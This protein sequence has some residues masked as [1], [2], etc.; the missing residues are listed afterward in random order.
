M[1]QF[2]PPLMAVSEAPGSSPRSTKDTPG[3]EVVARRHVDWREHR[4]RW[5]WLLDSYEGGERYRNAVYGRDR[6]GL[7]VRNLQ[8]HKREYPDLA[9][10]PNAQIGGS[11]GLTSSL[12]AEIAYGS[13]PGLLGADPNATSADDDYELRRSRTPPPEWVGECAEIHLGEVYDQEVKRDGPPELADEE[14]GWWADVD[15]KGTTIDDWMSLVISPMLLV[16]GQLDVLL[17]APPLPAG[18]QVKTLADVKRLGLDRCAASYILPENMLW[19]SLDRAG[20]YTE[21]VVQEFVDPSQW[22]ELAPGSDPKAS[23][24]WARDHVLFR[25]WTATYS[26]LYRYDGSRAENVREHPYGRVPIIRLF[27]RRKHRSAMVGKSRYEAVAELQREYYNRASELILSD[28][29][30]AHP[31]LSGPEQYCKPDG[32]L[33]IGPNF[34]LPKPKN[35]ADGTEAGKWEYVSPDKDPA[36]SIRKNLQDLIDAKDRSACLTK[37]AGA[38]GTGHGTVGQ[39]GVSKRLDHHTGKKLLSQIAHSLAKAERDLAEYALMVCR[40]R[41]LERADLAGL[42]ISYPSRFDLFSLTELADGITDLQTLV[43]G[44][45]ELPEAETLLIAALEK[46]LLPGLDDATYDRLDEEV[47]AMIATKSTMKDQGREALA[48][49]LGSQSD[50]GLAA[51]PADSGGGLDPTGKSGATSVTNTMPSFG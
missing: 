29:L 46:Q 32:T 23:A 6:K 33:S 14:A 28:V 30:Q 18:E 8:R 22:K 9:E 37:P 16:L 26:A 27:D 44:S 48:I 17:D 42:T 36:E 45:G 50:V 2:L 35:S 4:V 43:G 19:Y 41:P 5:Q 12:P 40:G 7:P 39:S 51:D 47:K 11:L 31:L 1:A 49:G 24:N 34:V 21:C 25:H 10:N 38:A 13:F 15:G 3:E 20:R